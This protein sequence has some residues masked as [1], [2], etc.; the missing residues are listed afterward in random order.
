MQE[1]KINRLI[2]ILLGIHC[3]EH[4]WGDLKE[5]GN[6]EDSGIDGRNLKMNLQD[7]GRDAGRGLFWLR[8]GIRGGLLLLRY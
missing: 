3:N 8:T 6:R 7:V 5:G 1:S 4:V 2:F